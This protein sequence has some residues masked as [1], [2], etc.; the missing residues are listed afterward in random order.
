MLIV[1][2]VCIVCKLKFDCNKQFGSELQ[3]VTSCQ[4]M[5]GDLAQPTNELES[6]NLLLAITNLTMDTSAE[7]WIGNFVQQFLSQ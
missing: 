3:A 7:F 2:I 4:S 1:C 6:D 5:G